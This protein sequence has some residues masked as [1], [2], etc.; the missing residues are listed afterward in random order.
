MKGKM[1]AMQDPFA[2]MVPAGQTYPQAPQL[3]GS[4]FTAVHVPLQQAV[5]VGQQTTF[6]QLPQSRLVL[7]LQARQAARHWFR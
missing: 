1:H 5:P 3:F 4:E 2:H 6:P 7:P